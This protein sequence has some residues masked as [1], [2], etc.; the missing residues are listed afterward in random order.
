[1]QNNQIPITKPIL[2]SKALEVSECRGISKYLMHSY[3]DFKNRYM[4]SFKCE[5][6]PVDIKTVNK[7]LNKLSHLC[8]IMNLKIF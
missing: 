1:M 8:K 4:I 5:F 2:K 7:F 3:K 6:A